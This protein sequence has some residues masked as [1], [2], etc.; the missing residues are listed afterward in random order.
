MK[1]SLTLTVLGLAIYLGVTL[2]A[3]KVVDTKAR[4]DSRLHLAQAS[5]GETCVNDNQCAPFER[6]TGFP[7][8]PGVCVPRK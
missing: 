1:L 3:L 7:G 2:T 6:C 8:Q 4:L 5:Y